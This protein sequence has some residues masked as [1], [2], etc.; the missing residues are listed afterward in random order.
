[1]LFIKETDTFGHI[2]VWTINTSHIDHLTPQH[3]AF[4]QSA[5]W[6]SVFLESLPVWYRLK[7][8]DTLGELKKKK[9]AWTWTTIIIIPQ[10]YL[11][12]FSSKMYKY[13]VE[14]YIFIIFAC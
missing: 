10:Q 3:T 5:A 6:L 12:V 9:V 2:V 8:C 14:I 4:E 13:L 1:M 7:Y 11:E